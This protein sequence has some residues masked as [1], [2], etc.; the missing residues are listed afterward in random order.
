MKDTTGLG[1]TGETYMVGM[2]GMFRSNS[3][4]FE[5]PTIANPSFLVDTESIVYALAGEDGETSVVNYRGDNVLSAYTAVSLYGTTWVLMVEID[6]GEAVV[7][8]VDEGEIDILTQFAKTYEFP[9][10]YLVS[11]DGY[12]F[13]SAERKKDYLTNILSGPYADSMFGRSVQEVLKTKEM[14]VSDYA[15]Y[16][17]AGGEATAS[18]QFRS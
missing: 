10:L 15:F 17:P 9:D 5:E 6:Q 14:A 11:T 7:P 3:R 4:H 13:A 8:A 16:E 2:D 1:E 12:V 18:W